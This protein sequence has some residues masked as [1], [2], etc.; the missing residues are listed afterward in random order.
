MYKEKIGMFIVFCL[1]L[2]FLTILVIAFIIDA[3]NKEKEYEK[4]ERDT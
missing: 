4:T 1:F 2:A 3:N